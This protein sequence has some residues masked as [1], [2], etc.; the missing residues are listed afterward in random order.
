M[1]VDGSLWTF[2]STMI[3]TE[4]ILQLPIEQ[5]NWA[6]PVEIPL[7]LPRSIHHDLK[8]QKCKPSQGN[9]GTTKDT[10][11]SVSP[12]ISFWIAIWVQSKSSIPSDPLSDIG[13][14][15]TSCR[16]TDMWTEWDG[17]AMGR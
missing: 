2:M 9:D 10:F 12:L 7:I 8:I 6:D 15:A 3:Y 16:K 17:Q 11:I 1:N 5:E 4:L 14:V 13:M